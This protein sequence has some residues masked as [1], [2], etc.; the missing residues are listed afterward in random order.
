MAQKNYKE[1]AAELAERVKTDYKPVQVIVEADDDNGIYVRPESG[2]N[3]TIHPV[4]DVVHFAEYH[5][6]SVLVSAYF[7]DLCMRLF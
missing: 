4:E 5:G 3:G 2:N 6:L 7:G 1:L